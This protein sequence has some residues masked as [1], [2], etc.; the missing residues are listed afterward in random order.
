MSFSKFR[1]TNRDTATATSNVQTTDRMVPLP[2]PTDVDV[3][4]LAGGFAKLAGKHVPPQAPSGVGYPQMKAFLQGFANLADG[5]F[6]IPGLKSTFLIALQIV[7]TAEAAKDNEQM[8]YNVSYHIYEMLKVVK[9]MS[10]PNDSDLQ[11]ICHSLTQELHSVYPAIKTLSSRHWLGHLFHANEDRSAI[12]DCEKFLNWSISR[13]QIKLQYL[14]LRKIDGLRNTQPTRK[15]TDDRFEFSVQIPQLPVGFCGRDSLIEQ[16]KRI[17]FG[18]KGANLAISGAGGMGKTTLAVA[19]LHDHDIK[20]YF[21]AQLHFVSCETIKSASQLINGLLLALGHG[22]ALNMTD[23]AGKQNRDPRAILYDILS[24]SGVMLVVLDNFETPWNEFG[25]Q[26]YVHNVLK[27]VA[28]LDNVTLI[29]TTRVNIVPSGIDWQPFLP[30]DILPPLDIPSAR[31]VF[32]KE[33]RLTIGGQ[34]SADL[35][36]LLRE[37]DCVPLAVSLLSRAQKSKSPT[38]LLRRWRDEK[39]SMLKALGHSTNTKLNSVEISIEVSLAPFGGSD[40]MKL[41]S[42]LSFLPAGIQEWESELYHMELGLDKL[43]ELANNLLAASLLQVS[44]GSLHMLS[45]I[46]HYIK[47]KYGDICKTEIRHLSEQHVQLIQE[48][49][50]G[51]EHVDN[52]K[53]LEQAKNIVSLL[54][55]AMNSFPSDTIFDAAYLYS[56]YLND[57]N[58]A[59]VELAATLLSGVQQKVVGENLLTEVC[60]MHITTVYDCEFMH[61]E[62]KNTCNLAFE[63]YKGKADEQGMADCLRKMGSILLF[64]SNYEAATEKLEAAH[65]RYSTIGLKEGMA[66]CL[67]GIGDI[68]LT[69]CNYEAAM[70]KFETAHLQY[71]DIGDWLGMVECLLSIAEILYA[72]S[73]YEVAMSKLEA[74]EFLCSTTGS[75]WGMANCLLSMGDNLLVQGK[76]ESAMEKLEAANAQFTSLGNKW[77]KARCLLSIGDVLYNKN[78][79]EAAMENLEA[80]YTQFI[81][82]GNRWGMANCLVSI[83][84]ILC[85]QRNHSAAMVKLEEAHGLYTAIGSKLGMANCLR[86]MGTILHDDGNYM[87]AVEM[88]EAAYVVYDAMEDKYSMVD[89]LKNIENMLHEQNNDQ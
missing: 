2:Q 16:A 7:Q 39:T 17:V 58:K 20:T 36:M 65:A 69:Q 67:R 1:R 29:I 42:L 45:P 89:C 24:T 61:E 77:G 46:Q 18:V 40:E 76:Y 54:V 80:A 51:N 6:S 26:A 34:E 78:N 64:Q 19:L 81:S 43:Q 74:A 31:A 32:L 11:D 10:L 8:C 56:Q 35:D 23:D 22:D 41:L 59:N 60:L 5:A 25:R 79:H 49:L 63:I 37:I 53:L 52:P 50:A 83:G 87:A 28:A 70:K 9:D 12:N 47:R 57:N 13:F 85:D 21:G 55:Q 33:A 3:S 72:H 30:D 4:Q 86:N 38:L 62:A 75:K 88:F 14:Q 48:S 27:D 15:M 68:L 73:K 44:D 82:I 66:D 71:T 84:D